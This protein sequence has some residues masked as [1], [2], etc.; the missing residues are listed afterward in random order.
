MAEAESPKQRESKTIRDPKLRRLIA[1]HKAG[2]P[3]SSAEKKY[4]ITAYRKMEK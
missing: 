4:L 2:K 3:L 1:A